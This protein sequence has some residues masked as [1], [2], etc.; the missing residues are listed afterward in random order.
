MAISAVLKNLTE[1]GHLSWTEELYQV[2]E[3]NC[4]REFD[5]EDDILIPVSHST[6]KAQIEVTLRDDGNIINASF[7]NKEQSTTIIPVTEDSGTRSSGICP[8]PFADKL[9]YIGGDYGKY[10]S[11]KCQDNS[12][13]F[14]MYMEQLRKWNESEYSHPAVDA[15]CKYLEKSTLISDLIEYGILETD[16]KTGKLKENKK[17]NGI[18]QDSS[19]VRFI[20]NYSDDFEHENRTW[21]DKTLY[22]SFIGFNQ[23]LFENTQL[24]YAT[25]KELPVTYKHPA[26]IRN[27]GDKAKLISSND[28][29]GFTYRG[30]FDNK[31]QAIS[32][33]YDFSQKVHKALSWLIARQGISFGSMNIIIWASAMQDV[34]KNL[35]FKASDGFMFDDDMDDEPIIPDTEPKHRKILEKMIFGKKE[36]YAPQSKIMIMGVD[37]ATTGRLSVSMYSELESSGFF[38]NILNWHMDMSWNRF[39]PKLKQ[40]I[41]N[42]FSLYEIIDCAFGLEQ[43]G[44]LTSKPE[45]VRDNILRLIPCVTEGRAVPSDIVQALFRKASNPLA[46]EKSYNHRTVLETACGLIKMNNLKRGGITN[47]AYDPNETDRSYL[48]G[49]LLAIADKAESITYDE[50]DRDSRITNA[51]R[52]WSSFSSRPY[53]TWKRIEESLRP[54]LNKMYG[55]TRRKYEA[56]LNE[57]HSKFTNNDYEDNTALETSYLLGYHNFMMYMKKDNNKD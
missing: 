49:C 16:D 5:G 40:Y 17:I 27:A 38:N 54:Y 9:V 12:V 46:Y 1:V 23:T 55:P 15:V 34:D 20:V 28:E 30:R 22:D 41:F 47:M 51:R 13:H 21:L 53:V 37:A 4:G 6:A 29:S 26:K 35:I 36:S 44:K 25:G 45:T 42:S 14:S 10:S 48:Y 19:F 50:K 32:V 57:V 18:E 7:V 33:G 31:E 43:G 11:G 8:M 52:Y 39:S 3:N 2:Y 56:L 24:C